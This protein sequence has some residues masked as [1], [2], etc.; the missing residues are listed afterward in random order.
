MRQSS[1]K[2]DRNQLVPCIETQLHQSHINKKTP[3]LAGFSLVAGL[4][5]GFSVPL[6]HLR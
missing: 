3:L 2:G 5:F 4:G 1:F 6:F